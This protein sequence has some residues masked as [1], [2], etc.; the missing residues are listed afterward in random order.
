MLIFHI[1]TTDPAGAA[2]NLVQA[3]NTY[4][5]HT[6][7]LLTMVPN[8]YKHPSDI[9]NIADY[10][11]E[12]EALLLDADIL[13]FHKITEDGSISFQSSRPRT[14]LI[15]D[16]LHVGNKK[17]KLVYHIHGHPYERNNVKENG[18]SYSKRDGVVLA[19]TPDLK[20]M[21]KPYC[22]VKFFP[23]C[24]PI[25]DSK[26]LPRQTDKIVKDKNGNERLIVSHTVSDPVLKDCELIEKAVEYVARTQPVNLMTIQNTPFAMAMLWKRIAHV[27]FDHMQGYYGLGSLEGLSMGK[28][29]IAGLNHNTI[30][31]IIDFFKIPY[32]LPWQ[33]ALNQ[34]G[35]NNALMDLIANRENRRIIGQQSRQFMET[36]WS[37]KNIGIKL[38]EFYES[39]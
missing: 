31:E 20:F 11:D 22:D 5:K 21:Y 39:L 15:K 24:V 27:I 33:I 3:T 16:F 9:S 34:S 18:E 28:P 14:W 10:G 26:Y 4:T 38:G 36:V 29:V 19:S 17:K 37:D 32:D 2:Y 25:W 30:R 23:N 6:A 8:V 12:V 1:T 35:L 7:R 13:H